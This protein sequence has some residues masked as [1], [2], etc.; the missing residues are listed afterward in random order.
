MELLE[1]RQPATHYA[2]LPQ[3]IDACEAM[4]QGK[5]L[6]IHGASESGKLRSVSVP[7]SVCFTPKMHVNSVTLKDCVALFMKRITWMLLN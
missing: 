6:Y 2:T 5:I 1:V 7:I 3:G 4:N